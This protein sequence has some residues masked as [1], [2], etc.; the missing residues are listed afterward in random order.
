M[1]SP[2]K[3]GDLADIIEGALGKTGP[4]IG[5]RVTVGYL[6]GQ[7]SEHGN[8]WSVSG[9]NLMSEYGAIGPTTQCAQKW[10]KKVEPPIPP[11][12]QQEQTKELCNGD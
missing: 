10:L 7:H 12:K 2:I 11:L 1:T 6:L 5:K 3:R 9:E 4:N 8:I